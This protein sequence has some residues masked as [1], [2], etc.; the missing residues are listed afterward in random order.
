MAKRLD[1]HFETQPR[2]ICR[3]KSSLELSVFDRLYKKQDSP[4]TTQP[5][6]TRAKSAGKVVQ[7]LMTKHMHS[8]AKIEKEREAMELE[9]L[10]ELRDRPLISPRSDY[11]AEKAVQR[12]LNE[13]VN[14]KTQAEIEAKPKVIR[15][16][17][18]VIERDSLEHVVLQA[19]S[20]TARLMRSTFNAE[21]FKP[22]CRVNL[23]TRSSSALGNYSSDEDKGKVEGLKILRD[24]LSTTYKVDV[25]EPPDLLELNFFER[26][27]YWE[28]AKRKRLATKLEAKSE[29]ERKEC[30]FKPEISEIPSRTLSRNSIPTLKSVK[31]STLHSRQQS[32]LKQSDVPTSVKASNKENINIKELSSQLLGLVDMKKS[33]SYSRLS[34]LSVTFKYKSG[35]NEKKFKK[36][37]V[38]K[39]TANYLLRDLKA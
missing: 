15:P 31:Y 13:L 35:F 3:P 6:H 9:L 22:H 24:L 12:E 10:K 25:E 11:I 4:P 30:T 36:E 17:T 2:R 7:R 28:E 37:K 14:G 19:A 38:P 16:L 1:Y 23:L 34:P 27:R 32:S 26:G 21:D 33:S 29:K 18:P 5:S 39:L 8:L 20:V